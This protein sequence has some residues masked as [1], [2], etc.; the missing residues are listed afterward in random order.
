MSSSCAGAL[1]LLAPSLFAQ[2]ISFE[3][4]GLHY[5]TLSRA[6]V[7]VMCAPL[8]QQVREYSVMQ[9]AVT[10]GSPSNRTVKPEDFTFVREDGTSIRA[11]S[12]QAVVGE[13]LNKAGRN[14]VIR[15]VAAYETALYGVDKFKSTNGY[16]QRRQQF[17]ASAGSSKL[18]AAAAASALAFVTT[19]LASGESTDGAIFFDTQGR[20]LGVG[21]LIAVE[22][23]ET[24]EFEIGGL[25]HPGEL[26]TR[27]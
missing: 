18:T 12:A 11:A 24:F 20:P 2:A 27:Q 13:L 1:L 6:G 23:V 22:G 7:T 3:S 5:Q 26:K 10:N 15:L 16:E 17:L 4:G 19:R 9:V 25:K 8:P 14:D 21:K